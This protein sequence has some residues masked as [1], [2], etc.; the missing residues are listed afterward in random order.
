MSITN[1]GAFGEPEGVAVVA[2]KTGGAG[3]TTTAGGDL[4]L[5][6]QVTELV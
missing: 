3:N 1:P 4:L 5:L 6:L 2:V